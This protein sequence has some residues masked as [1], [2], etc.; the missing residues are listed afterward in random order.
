M[1]DLESAEI[2]MALDE[3]REQKAM[4]RSVKNWDQKLWEQHRWAVVKKGNMAK[5]RIIGSRLELITFVIQFSL[6]M[7]YVACM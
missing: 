3:P 7:Y 4:G 1:G 6:V 2:I 5:V